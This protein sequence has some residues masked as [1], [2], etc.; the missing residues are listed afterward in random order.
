MLPL[1]H[2]CL[3]Y[4]NAVASYVQKI[5]S[6][7]MH[8]LPY[9]ELPIGT[10]YLELNQL[11]RCDF[12]C[13]E[14]HSSLRFS[15]VLGEG[16]SDRGRCLSAHTYVRFYC[17]NAAIKASETC[18]ATQPKPFWLYDTYVESLDIPPHETLLT[19][20][21]RQNSSGFLKHS[22]YTHYCSYWKNQARK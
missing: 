5:K 20:I 7:S 18:S 9:S 11:L 15:G 10:P 3:C 4:T 6:S 22:C 19:F 17:L 21:D 8:K 1:H 14:L 16:F 12:H 2:R 13:E